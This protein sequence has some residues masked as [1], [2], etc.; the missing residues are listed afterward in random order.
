[1][2]EVLLLHGN[3]RPHTSLRMREAIA[4]VGWTVLPHPAHSP[5][6]TPCDYHLFRPETDALR[7]HHFT[8]G[9]ELKQVFVM[10]SEFEA[11]NFTTLVYSA[12]LNT[13]KRV[14]KM[15]RLCA[16]IAS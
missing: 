1:M 12:L 3:A 16:N 8:D 11:G 7:G 9:N 13:G 10:C 4:K 5:D 14:L 2:K 6:L 15:K